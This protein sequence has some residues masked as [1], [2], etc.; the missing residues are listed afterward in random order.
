[1]ADTKT[2]ET[3]GRDPALVKKRKELAE[4][5]LRSKIA[6]EHAKTANDAKK[7]LMNRTKALAAELGR[8]FG[9]KKK[10]AEA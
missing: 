3:A 7:E 9:R 1:M 2:G 5:R 8:P 6:A 10:A 4:L